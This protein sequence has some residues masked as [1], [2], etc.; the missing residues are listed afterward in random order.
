[1]NMVSTSGDTLHHHHPLSVSVGGTDEEGELD[2]AASQ[3]EDGRTRRYAPQTL[4]HF[5]FYNTIF[6]VVFFETQYR[7]FPLA[8][9]I[10]TRILTVVRHVSHV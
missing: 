7:E 4:L 9:S 2:L 3:D 5:T 10:S 8:T 6:F 1:M